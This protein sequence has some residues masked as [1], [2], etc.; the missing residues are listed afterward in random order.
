M[1]KKV[2]SMGFQATA[3]SRCLRERSQGAWQSH[4]RHHI[5]LTEITTSPSLL[6]MTTIETRAQMGSS[7]SSINMYQI[8]SRDG[9][10]VPD[11]RNLLII[12][13][14]GSSLGT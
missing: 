5:A 1:L 8:D 10:R 3:M 9:F 11:S 6:V 12:N 7:T 2:I 4:V 14:K 13:A